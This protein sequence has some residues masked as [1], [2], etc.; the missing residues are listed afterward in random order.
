M[1][2][3]MHTLGFFHEHNRVDRDDWVTIHRRNIAPGEEDQFERLD[4]A[5]I[6]HLDTRETASFP[7][8]TFSI[9]HPAYDFASIMHYNSHA[10]SVNGQ[11]TITANFP[12][13]ALVMG[14]LNDLSPSDIWRN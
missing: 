4:A 1:H 3:M 6:T 11:P 9:L 13:S 10:F 7:K 2:E 12:P 14:Q 5:A 8:Q